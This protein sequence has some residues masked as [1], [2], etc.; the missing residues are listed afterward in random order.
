MHETAGET[1]PDR[2]SSR[3]TSVM[4]PP[5]HTC[6]ATNRDWKPQYAAVKK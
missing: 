5:A 4:L 1:W 2:A 3:C 6:V